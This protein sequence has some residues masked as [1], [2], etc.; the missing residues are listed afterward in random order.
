[1]FTVADAAMR[2][3]SLILLEC[4]PRRGTAAPRVPLLW[5]HHATEIADALSP[6]ELVQVAGPEEAEEAAMDGAVLGF[7][8]IVSVGGPSVAHGLVNGIMRLAEGHRRR[9]KIGFLSLM[10]RPWLPSLGGPDVL[11]RQLDILAA[12][13]TLPFDVGRLECVHPES[14]RPTV[15]HFLSSAACGALGPVWPPV[16]TAA[17]APSLALALPS[18]SA[19]ARLTGGLLAAGGQSA[20]HGAAPVSLRI[21]GVEVFR[22]PWAL[23]WVLVARRYPLLGTWGPADAESDGVRAESALDA[24]WIPA[25]SL[26]GFTKHTA[27][28]WLRGALPQAP[29]RHLG[30]ELHIEPLEGTIQN[31]VADGVPA[32][33]L[34]AVL[35]V[36]PRALPVMVESVAAR[37]RERTSVLARL[38]DAALAGDARAVGVPRSAQRSWL[39]R[40]H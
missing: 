9:M 6:L 22:G 26:A 19:L 17:G 36:V 8:R 32:G 24:T 20:S 18:P 33:R 25:D 12:G 16:P 13:H 31:I 28:Q 7:T 27:G 2:Q 23:G 40:V 35:R 4:R 10:P 29:P 14:G 30:S 15:R 3:P 11:A 38:R 5:R 21:D 1:V 37:L 34:P 39:K